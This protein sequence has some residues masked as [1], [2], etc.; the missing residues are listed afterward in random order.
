MD[1]DGLFHVIRKIKVP[2]K[3]I[4]NPE[5]NHSNAIYVFCNSPLHIKI[6]T[7]PY[8]H[9]HSEWLAVALNSNSSEC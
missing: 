8:D 1:F 4:I 9:F 2:L 7:H 3:I 5:A 6:F